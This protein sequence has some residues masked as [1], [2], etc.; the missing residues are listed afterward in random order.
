MRTSGS[1]ATRTQAVTILT[2]PPSYSTVT[3]NRWLPGFFLV[4]SAWNLTY[5]CEF[6]SSKLRSASETRQ[7]QD[8]ETRKILT[9]F[10]LTLR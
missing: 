1:Y 10:A 2:L 6:G 8:P 3:L 9:G 7:E 5:P 4:T